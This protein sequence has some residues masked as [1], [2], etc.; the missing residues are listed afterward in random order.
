MCVDRIQWHTL[1]VCKI[2]QNVKLMLENIVHVFQSNISGYPPDEFC[3]SSSLLENFNIPDLKYINHYS[4]CLALLQCNPPQ[5]VCF[6]GQ[7]N[8]CPYKE[9]FRSIN[10]H[11]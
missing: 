7:C 10:S 5:E 3:S 9:A 1:C 4:H 2:H 11:I 8:Q 6:F